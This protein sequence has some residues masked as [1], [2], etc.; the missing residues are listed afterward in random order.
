M[1]REELVVDKSKL[2]KGLCP[3][4]KLDVYFPGFPTL[5]HIA[6]TVSDNVISFYV[7]IKLDLFNFMQQN[8]A[9]NHDM[10]KRI[11]RMVEL[12]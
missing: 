6:F 1:C 12:N 9:Y 10:R 7:N 4:V 3:G 2:V 5:K 8:T 11:F